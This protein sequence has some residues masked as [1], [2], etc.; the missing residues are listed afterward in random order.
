V[1]K[2][3]FLIK[4]ILMI[5]SHLQRPYRR[6][7]SHRRHRTHV[8]LYA[9]HVFLQLALYELHNFSIGICPPNLLLSA[10]LPFCH[11]GL[12]WPLLLHYGSFR[13]TKHNVYIPPGYITPESQVSPPCLAH[14]HLH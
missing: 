7:R 1:S 11:T 8:L 6:H 4:I 9:Y 2:I 3:L 5:R 13:V 10:A 12:P 14:S